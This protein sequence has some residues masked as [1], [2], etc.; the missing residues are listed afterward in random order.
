M[1]T[2]LA[3]STLT[4][5]RIGE[6]VAQCNAR[7]GE[8]KLEDEGQKFYEKSGF[9]IAIVF[10]DNGKC[11]Q[12]HYLKSG[13]S[14]N[15]TEKETKAFMNAN[16]SSWK[17]TKVNDTYI[18]WESGGKFAYDTS[19]T[20]LIRTIAHDAFALAEADRK[21]AEKLNAF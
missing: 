19:G 7:Y 8:V 18:K 13:S 20:L 21:E 14:N 17:R 4:H 3:L 9:T 11:C 16:G 6:T 15:L 12:I 1:L 5:A 2:V 10:D